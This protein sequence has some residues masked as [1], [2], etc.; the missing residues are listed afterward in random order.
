MSLE[1]HPVGDAALR[2]QW[3]ELAERTGASPFLRAGWIIAW[4]RA[5]ARRPVQVAAL[6]RDGRLAAVLPVVLW[7]GLVRS[8]ANWHSPVF[9]PVHEDAAAGRE[10]L[11][12]LLARRPRRLAL[13]FADPDASELLRTAASAAGYRISERPRMDS[14]YLE[15]DGEPA[16]KRLT[17]KRRSNLRRQRRKLEALGALSLEV[18]DRASALDEALPVEGSGWKDEEGTAIASRPETERFYREVAAWAQECG[19]LRILL[20]RCGE[21]VIACDIGLDACGSHHLLKTGYAHDLSSHSPGVV[22]RHD[23]IERA[24][25][26]GLSTYEFLGSAEP[27]KLEWTDR[28]RTRVLTQVFSPTPLGRL[29]RLVVV[30]GGS[31]VRARMRS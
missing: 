10:L 28:C 24:Q 14:P 12:A 27:T 23:A 29:E 9:G 6:R 5:F 31:A 4:A 16:E 11:S 2:V 17:S 7:P 18:H 3:D 8:P 15:F 22:L 21:R 1:L 20:L 26:A 19:W 25:T 30:R 13:D